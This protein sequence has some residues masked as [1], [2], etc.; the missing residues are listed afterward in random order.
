MNK[1][2]SLLKVEKR[3][4]TLIW[5]VNERPDLD[6]TAEVK[7]MIQDMSLDLSGAQK[8]ELEWFVTRKFPKYR[9]NSP[10]ICSPPQLIWR[11]LRA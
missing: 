2:P 7:A 4:W 8:T 5:A 6:L 10:L 1:P 3:I 9:Y 11:Q